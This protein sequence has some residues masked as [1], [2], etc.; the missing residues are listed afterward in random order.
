MAEANIPISQERALKAGKSTRFLVSE[1]CD[2]LDT[3]L[4]PTEVSAIYHAYLFSAE[5]HEG[6]QRLSGEPYIYHPLAVAKIMAEMH[7]DE[8]SIMAAILHDVIEDTPTAKE[9]IHEQFGQHVAELVDGVSKLT[10]LSFS[11]KQEA[12]AENFRKMMLAMVRDIRII[13]IKLADR[14]HNLRTI[15]IM[16]QDKQRRIAR[17]TM[18]IYVPIAQRL[19]MHK[20]RLELEMLCFKAIHPYRYSV[21]ENV[22]NKNRRNRK[23]VMKDVETSICAQLEDNKIES[24]IFGREKNLYSIYKKMRTKHI[25]FSEVHDI[26]AIRIIVNDV[27]TCYRALGLVHNLFKPVPG[28]FKDYIAIPK[29]NG[30]QSL[31][32]ILFGPRGIKIEVQIRTLEMDLIAESG[33]AAHWIY[34]SLNDRGSILPPAESTHE[35][36]SDIE[37]MQDNAVSS[38]DFFETVKVDLFPDEIYVFTPVGDIIALPRGSSAVDFAYAVHSDLG[39]TCFAVKIDRR[40]SPLS[41]TLQSGQTI[42]IMVNPSARPKPS[43][44]NFVVTSKARTN[45]RD[46]LKHLQSEEAI[47]LGERL[48]DNALAWYQKTPEDIS[49]TDIKRI[50]KV[51]NVKT[52]DELY[53]AIGLG[54]Q[55]AELLVRNVSVISADQAKNELARKQVPLSIQGTEG[56]VVNYAKCCHPIPGDPIIGIMTR[57]KGLVVHR[58]TCRNFDSKNVFK[59][60][61]ITLSWSDDHIQ[62]F[63]VEVRVQTANQRGVL[64]SLAAKIANEESNIENLELED[65]DDASTTITFLLSVKDRKHLA[66]IM[67]ILRSIPHVF[68]VMRIRH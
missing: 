47:E 7:L 13:I 57:G 17:E 62:D 5:A 35:W 8:Q 26:Y 12:Q 38:I 16:R 21:L 15:G 11:S 32:T 48:F 59:D 14:L 30:Y 41:A 33:I 27:D 67:R 54:E 49:K 40:I 2:L 31:H 65:Q 3:Y 10:H 68:K 44:L 29:K 64:A 1:L 60:K 4:G 20:I 56:V 51:A 23:Q 19:G 66:R 9:Q 58:E 22:V 36:L 37:E 55:L 24:R 45:I 50:L 18:D 46:Y 28:R 61:G 25:T 52:I 43:W 6:Q 42:E 63:H 34:K 39:N 53:V